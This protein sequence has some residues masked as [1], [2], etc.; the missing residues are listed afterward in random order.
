[1]FVFRRDDDQQR[2]S[3]L[4]TDRETDGGGIGGGVSDDVDKFWLLHDSWEF[5]SA[6]MISSLPVMDRI[7]N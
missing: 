6:N 3:A 4:K 5:R 1:M 7:D 2:F